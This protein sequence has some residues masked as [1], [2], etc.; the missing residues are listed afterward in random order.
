MLGIFR[1]PVG[2]ALFQQ[3]K[4]VAKRFRKVT[5]SPFLFTPPAQIRV[6][7]WAH[8]SYNGTS[9]AYPVTELEEKI[10]FTAPSILFSTDG[11]QWEKCDLK[12]KEE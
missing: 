2:G 8:S 7:M 11:Q 6:A 4:T 1:K 3:F 10:G 5:K 9:K 12:K